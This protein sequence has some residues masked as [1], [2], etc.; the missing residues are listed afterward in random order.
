LQDKFES[1]FPRAY[2]QDH[3]F[4][5]EYQ[6]EAET[7]FKIAKEE[8]QE[9]RI[10]SDL[11]FLKVPQNIQQTI[12]RSIERDNIR[13]KMKEIL[14]KVTGPSKYTFMNNIFIP[15]GRSFFSL[16]QKNIFIFLRTMNTTDPFLLEFGM[17]YEKIKQIECGI[18]PEAQT[19]IYAVLKGDYMYK[20]KLLLHDGGRKIPL[21]LLSSGQQ[22]ALPLALI[23]AY[24][25]ALRP[26]ARDFT[27]Y[28]EEPE[29]HLFPEAQEQIARLISFVQHNSAQ[30]TGFVITTHSP[31]MLTAFNNLIMAGNIVKQNPECKEAVCK[32]IPESMH[33]DIDRFSAYFLAD[34]K[35]VSI[36]NR[37]NNLIDAETIDG[38]SESIGE[39]FG[40]LLDIEIEFES[41]KE[42]GNV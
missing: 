13:E 1:F 21:E 38:V 25:L 28:I 42:G 24:I 41:K 22:E 29:A 11:A 16:L 40:K 37:E 3:E 12:Q 2:W 35:A 39:T 32:I 17:F 14:E 4:H 8:N 26:Q 9:L 36:I 27:V 23:L 19:L 18:P 20:E 30:K 15:A 33:I 6:C 7:W 5:I 31:Y 10:S 34:G